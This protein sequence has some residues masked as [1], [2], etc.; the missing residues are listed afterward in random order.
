MGQRRGL[1]NR[2]SFCGRSAQKPCRSKPVGVKSPDVLQG[3]IGP[4][5]SNKEA[6]MF[7]VSVS[8]YV[9]ESGLAWENASALALRL[10]RSGYMPVVSRGDGTRYAGREFGGQREGYLEVAPNLFVGP[11]G[12]WRP[13]TD[14]RDQSPFIVQPEPSVEF[15]LELVTDWPCAA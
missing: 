15:R 14:R 9:I 11:E 13:T 4:P 8:G 10:R 6:Q 5:V 3:G 2:R 7:R 12:F 1:R